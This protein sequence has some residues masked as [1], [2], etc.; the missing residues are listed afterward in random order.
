MWVGE[1]DVSLL[2]A[3]EVFIFSGKS[4]RFLSDPHAYPAFDDWVKFINM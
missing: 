2:R 4:Q 3:G 1:E